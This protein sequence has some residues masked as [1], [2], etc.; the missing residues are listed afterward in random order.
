[1]N[2]NESN[3]ISENNGRYKTDDDFIIT[4]YILHVP[5]RHSIHPYEMKLHV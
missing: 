3:L 1:M 5:K 4:R 2:I